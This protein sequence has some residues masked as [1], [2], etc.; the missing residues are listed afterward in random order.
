MT[1][2]KREAC[3][4]SPWTLPRFLKNRTGSEFSVTEAPCPLPPACK[5]VAGGIRTLLRDSAL[6]VAW[7]SSDHRMNLSPSQSDCEGIVILC[8]TLPKRQKTEIGS[9]RRMTGA[10]PIPHSLGVG[11]WTGRQKDRP[12]DQQ[13]YRNDCPSV[14]PPSPQPVNRAAVG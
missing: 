9:V 5:S 13:S 6:M 2:R 3:N 7:R 1:E 4:H 8:A 11:L 10:W 12:L 14:C